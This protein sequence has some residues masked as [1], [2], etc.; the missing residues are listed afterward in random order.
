MSNDGC[1]RKRMPR[2]AS[3]PAAALMLLASLQAWAG[4]DVAAVR[5]LTVAAR[6]EASARVE[7]ITILRLRAAQA[8]MISGLKVLPGDNVRA[9]DVLARLR[10]PAVESLLV[11]RRNEVA[12]AVAAMSAARET[13]AGERRK[14][15]EQLSTRRE[16]SHAEAALAESQALLDSARS[17]LA[18]TLAALVLQ[19]PISAT[20]LSIGAAEGEMVQPGQTIM[21]LQQ[22]GA[23]WFKAR[24]YGSDATA[25][26]VGMRGRFLPASGA[27][28]VAVKVRTIVGLLQNDGS[29][30]VG[31]IATAPRPVLRSGET[32]TVVLEGAART[33]AAV[34]TRARI[35]DKGR[36]WVLV[37]TGGGNRPREVT[38]G[39]SRGDM[40]LIERGL[41]AGAEVVV[42]NAYLEFHREFSKRY[43]PPD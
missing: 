28:A 38:L 5:S 36:W 8:G 10:G 26:R 43:Q 22:S 35:L 7:P 1:I 41:E 6:M 16:V 19:A 29:L 40:T 33:M 17:R 27:P 11:Q 42:E 14:L 20:V 21:T 2:L 12:G 25:V 24:Y 9:G 39:P 34:P 4:P 37:R 3:W 13:L 30:E 32:G 23:L 18:S 15:A 31:L